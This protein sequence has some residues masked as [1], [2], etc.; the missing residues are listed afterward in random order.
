MRRASAQETAFG[1]W[2]RAQPHGAITQAMHGTKLAWSTVNKA[3]KRRT[4]LEVA[5]KLSKY[6]RGEVPVAEIAKA[7]G[8]V[9]TRAAVAVRVRRAVRAKGRAAA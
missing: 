4:S 3:R 2:L 9:V 6:T 8:S 5:I 1:R 7:K